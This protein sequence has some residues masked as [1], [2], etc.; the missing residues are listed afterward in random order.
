GDGVRADQV[1]VVDL[2]GHHFEQQAI[3]VGGQ[4]RRL[5]GILDA[6]DRL[7]NGG[8]AARLRRSRLYGGRRRRPS[9]ALSARPPARRRQRGGGP[10][11][12]Q[13]CRRLGGRPP[14]PPAARGWGAPEGRAGGLAPLERRGPGLL[15]V[16]FGIEREVG[17]FVGEPDHARQLLAQ[18]LAE[19]ARAG[20]TG[21]D[22]LLVPEGTHGALGQSLQRDGC[23]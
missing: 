17:R 7:L 22:G 9:P 18:Q 3:F 2:L 8:R 10:R 14:Q 21:A 16:A 6:G 15:A 12:F 19:A 1:V 20:P 5:A 23:V 11:P 4:R 13:G